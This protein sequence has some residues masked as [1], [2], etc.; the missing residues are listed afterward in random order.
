[1]TQLSDSFE[2]LFTELRTYVDSNDADAR[3]QFT[4]IKKYIRFVD[5]N[6]VLGDSENK[7]TL[8]IENGKIVFLDNGAEVA[9]FTDQQ[10]Y[11]THGR[12][13]NSVRIG[14]FSFIPRD[15]NNLSLVKVGGS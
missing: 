4:E 11:V 7:L 15:N 14:N 13:L 5:G 6:I 3:E 2:F 12:F 10:L 9:Y 1:M 8:R